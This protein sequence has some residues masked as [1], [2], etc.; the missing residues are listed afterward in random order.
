[1]NANHDIPGNM[2]ARVT[3]DRAIGREFHYWIGA[4]GTRYLHTVFAP[5]DCPAL[6]EA[7]Y[8]A[9]R[10]ARDG[11]RRA[12]SVGLFGPFGGGCEIAAAARLGAGEIHVH[13]M[14]DTPAARRAV[15]RDLAA[16]HLAEAGSLVTAPVEV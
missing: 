1:M 5:A 3:L 6:D 9:V 7:V 10:R 16:R 12:L 15:L 2:P 11:R 13:L 4:S 14:A 8:V